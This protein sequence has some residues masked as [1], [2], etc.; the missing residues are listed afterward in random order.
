MS[1]GSRKAGTGKYSGKKMSEACLQ[2]AVTQRTPVEM[3][4]ESFLGPPSSKVAGSKAVVLPKMSYYEYVS[5]IFLE[6]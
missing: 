6:F 4:W 3:L 2:V 5:K 1:L